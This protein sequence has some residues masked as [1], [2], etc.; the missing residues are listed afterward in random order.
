MIYWFTGQP[1]AGKTVLATALKQ[2][3]NDVFHVDG[4]DFDMPLS[5]LERVLIPQLA[6]AVPPNGFLSYGAV[7]TKVL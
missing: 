7:L 3:L 5:T 6:R 2:Q 1:G 4:D